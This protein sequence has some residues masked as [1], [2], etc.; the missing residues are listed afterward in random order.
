MK[1]EMFP[2][3]LEEAKKDSVWAEKVRKAATAEEV[4]RLYNEKGIDIAEEIKLKA[5]EMEKGI[6]K[7]DDE[8][9]TNVAGGSIFGCKKEYDVL[10]CA[11]TFCLHLEIKWHTPE[12]GKATYSCKKYSWKMI[13]G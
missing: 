13:V 5:S 3:Q 6:K 1:N 4:I 12:E 9:L 8:E 7:L 2:K 11:W 10:L